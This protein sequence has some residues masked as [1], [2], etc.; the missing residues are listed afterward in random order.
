MVS[1]GVQALTHMQRARTQPLDFAPS[2][3]RHL[4]VSYCAQELS[5]ENLKQRALNL[6]DTCGDKLP[7]LQKSAP[8][9]VVS[10]WIIDAQVALAFAAGLNLRHTDF[11][12]P[13]TL[14]APTHI[15][16]DKE[17]KRFAEAGYTVPTSSDADE[18]AA[19]IEQSKASVVAPLGTLAPPTKPAQPAF[20]Q[21]VS[22]TQAHYGNPALSPS[23][24]E[25]T[26]VG[27]PKRLGPPL[28]LG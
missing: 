23:K 17:R 18:A 11:G 24:G 6:A 7:P 21:R 4:D 3:S 2:R 28:R 26:R 10:R 5:R 15:L 8:R 22:T 27:V 14:M 20:M 13:A 1:L 25:N 16:S 19:E 9:P 12:M